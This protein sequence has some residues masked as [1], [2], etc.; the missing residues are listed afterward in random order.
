MA[1]VS[2]PLKEQ[3]S[4]LHGA[5]RELLMTQRQMAGLCQIHPRTFCDWMKGRY[6]M[7]YESLQQFLQRTQLSLGRDIGQIPEFSHVRAAASRQTGSV[8]PS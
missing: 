3:V 6:R 8:S 5:Q 2:L 7:R 4:F 1:R